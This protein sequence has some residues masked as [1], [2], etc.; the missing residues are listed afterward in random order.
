MKQILEKQTA[1]LEFL[2]DR[3]I[4]SEALQIAQL[5]VAEKGMVFTSG[6]ALNANIIKLGDQIKQMS[7]ALLGVF[8]TSM[9]EKLELERDRKRQLDLLEKIDENTKA[10]GTT[11]KKTT[12][13]LGLIGTILAATLGGLVGV[14][15]SYVK[16]I[17]VFSKAFYA[18]LVKLSDVFP[19]LKKVLLNIEL[20]L[21]FAGQRI[22]S[23]FKSIV[24]SIDEV[25]G[26]IKKFFSI[27]GESKI[28]KLF[29][30]F[31]EGISKFFAPIEDAFSTLKKVS[32]P[33]SSLA[34]KMS[35]IFTSIAEFFTGVVS[36]M[37]M[38]G[39][40]FTA[41][42][43]I[44][45]AIALPVQVI[46]TLYDTVIGAVEGFQK[47]GLVGGI[48]GAITGFFNSLVFGIAD[49]IKN[50]ASWVLEKLGFDNAAETLDS[51]S[52]QDVFKKFIDAIFSPVETLKSMFS[53]LLKMLE[54]VGIP[55]ITLLDNKLTGKVSIGPYYPFK[56]DQK[57]SEPSV[58]KKEQTA[59]ISKSNQSSK[60]ESV[61]VN[62]PNGPAVYG[63]V[64]EAKR[65]G[66]QQSNIISSNIST[67]SAMIEKNNNMVS[68][69]IYNKS[70]QNTETAMT[71]NKQVAPVIVNAPTSVNNTNKQSIAMPAPVRNEDSALSRYVN[72][73]AVF[74]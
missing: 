53:G 44:F 37:S 32:A 54:N 2:V 66:V 33:V 64:E 67:Q 23:I 72:N 63:S 49:L 55:E 41:V 25:A 61:V 4:E 50:A 26:S 20:N 24:G 18:G 70:A 68:N 69:A 45:K 57:P 6:N 30:A 28:G 52:F 51:F 35:N 56:S 65:A 5:Y 46:M 19:A 47:E 62:T 27:S 3:S 29:S 1:A 14:L 7:D 9:E 10:T 16:N 36:K 21:D 43:G 34:S 17:Q 15:Q 60:L 31:T 42:K 59:S 38:F 13:P 8:K 40:V 73:R 48:K 11:D 71:T 22:K 74:V 12:N 58:Q 39:K